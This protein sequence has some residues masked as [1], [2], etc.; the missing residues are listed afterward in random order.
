M[1]KVSVIKTVIKSIPMHHT[2]Q[3]NCNYMYK[4][5]YCILQYIWIQN[6]NK[7][8]SGSFENILIIWTLLLLPNQIILTTYKYF[9]KLKKKF[10]R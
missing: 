6:K 2:N 3:R 10:V 5:G 4:K 7:K 8:E 9:H 1:L